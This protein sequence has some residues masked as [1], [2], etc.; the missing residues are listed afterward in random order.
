[1]VTAASIPESS[2]APLVG[3]G[4]SLVWGVGTK[5]NLDSTDPKMPSRYLGILCS[6]RTF[7]GDVVSTKGGFEAGEE[8]H[9]RYRYRVQASRFSFHS[10]G[11]YHISMVALP[12]CAHTPPRHPCAKAGSTSRAYR[13][14]RHCFDIIGVYCTCLCEN[15]RVY[16]GMMM[17][18][19]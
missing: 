2:K 11:R 9:P 7:V 18:H 8:H 14:C 19:A 17:L 6:L 1:M 16:R 12:S 4:L 5:Y 15:L 10:F 13:A 3:H